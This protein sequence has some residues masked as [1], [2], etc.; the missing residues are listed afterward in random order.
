MNEIVVHTHLKKGKAYIALDSAFNFYYEDNINFL[1]KKFEVEFF[2]PLNNDI[3][4]EDAEVIYI[5]GGY[6]ELHLEELEKATGTK[7]WI[8]RNIEAGKKVIAECG[9][10]MYLSKELISPEEKSYR[11]VEAFDISIRT[12]DK[13]TIGYTELEGVRDSFIAKRGDT[14]RGHEFHVS[15]PINVNDV[16]F[17]FRNKIGKGIW[18]GRDGAVVNNTIA[19]YSHLYFSSIR[20]LSF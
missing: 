20:G 7:K 13:L 6:P 10:L 9:G 11:M 4:K 15:K 2:S 3:P 18:E 1:R 12:K 17:A 16:T 5:G 14:I 19:L 8:L